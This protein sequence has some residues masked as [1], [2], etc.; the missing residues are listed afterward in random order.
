MW[1]HLFRTFS[2]H[3]HL[4]LAPEDLITRFVNCLVRLPNLRT[5]EI[6]SAGPRTP[7][8]KALKRKYATFPSIRELRITPACHHFIKN[9]PNLDSL[10]FTRSLDM[11]APATV[12]S[13]GKGL[14]RIMGV[15]VQRW[16]GMHGKFLNKSPGYNDYSEEAWYSGCFGLPETSGNRNHR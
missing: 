13:H 12:I 14:R 16:R 4:S 7:I 9:C 5:L 1:Y 15:P 2:V 8:S 3:L 11:H 10:T 6:L